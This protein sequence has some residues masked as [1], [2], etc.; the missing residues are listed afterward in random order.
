MV[1]PQAKASDDIYNCGGCGG[2]TTTVLVLCIGIEPRLQMAYTIVVVVV[3]V[4][5]Y[6]YYV[7]VL[8]QDFRWDIIVVAVVMVVG[9]VGEGSVV[10]GAYPV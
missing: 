9:L 7:L 8:N 4:P 1:S 2:D 6:W 5:L 3:V 10:N